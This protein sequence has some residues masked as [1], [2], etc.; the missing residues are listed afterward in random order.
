MLS[1]VITVLLSAC[2]G[3]LEIRNGEELIKFAA[4]VNDEGYDFSDETVFLTSDIDMSTFTA[5]FT[6]IG[7]DGNSFRGTF[8]GHGHII[9]NLAVTSSASSYVGLF[10]C[11]YEAVFKNTVLLHCEGICR[12]HCFCWGFCESQLI[13][14]SRCLSGRA[15]QCCCHQVL[16]AS[17]VNHMLE[18]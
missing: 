5:N 16:S 14:F 13:L 12:R 17:T 1:F 3:D 18:I 15:G 6:P 10:G 9:S 2:F 11:A 4:K 8:D 7:T